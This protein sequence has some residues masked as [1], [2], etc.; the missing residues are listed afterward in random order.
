M[1]DHQE[2]WQIFASNGDPVAGQSI[3]PVESR[4]T[5]KVIVGAVH[6][7][8]WRR[9]ENNVEV[10]LQ[11]RAKNK[12]TWP[13]YLDISVA[14]HIDAGETLLEAAVRE[15]KEEIGVQFDV[16]NLKY[17]FGYRN[18]QNG[19][20]SV[21]L[22]EVIKPES[23]SF[24]DGEVQSLDWV[25]LEQFEQMSVSPEAHNLVPHPSE[26]FGLLIK[27]LRYMYENH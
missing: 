15:G 7:W 27:A 2:E 24:N 26:Y 20:K 9:V 17:I 12:P 25:S 14:G 19:L 11:H 4:K 8:M 21:Y 18:F 6:V 5:E 13:D 1:I 3:L 22:Y 10:L 16:A 23:Y